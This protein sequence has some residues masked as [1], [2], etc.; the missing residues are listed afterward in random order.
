MRTSL[1]EIKLIDDYLFNCAEPGD[2]V[3]LDAMLLIDSELPEK[4]SWQQQTHAVI[5]NYSRKMLKSEIEAVH[6]QL[7]NRPEHLD[8]KKF[9]ISLFRKK[10]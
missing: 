4:I 8:F 2:A 9:I 5:K 6:R 7:F 3:L 1:T 10:N